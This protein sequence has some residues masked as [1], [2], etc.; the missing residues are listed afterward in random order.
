M[1]ANRLARLAAH[2]QP[3]RGDAHDYASRAAAAE[4]RPD[5]VVIVAAVRSPICRARR[6]GLAVVTPDA[7]LSQTLQGAMDRVPNL[8][9]AEL[10]DICI[11][12]VLQPGGGAGMARAAQLMAGI[13]PTVPLSTVNRQC[14]SGLQAV[15]HIVHAI[16]AGTIDCG[17]GGGVESMSKDSMKGAVPKLDWGGIKACAPAA[18]CLIPMG[19]TSE[20]VAKDFGISRREQDAFAAESQR[21]AA[22]S[23]RL[24]KFRAETVPIMTPKRGEM[25]GAPVVVTEDDG[26]RPG[27]DLRALGRL[28]PAFQKGGSTT[29]G[30][31]SQ[32]SDGAA[33]VILARRSYAEQRGWPVLGTFVA[34]AVV[35]VPPRIMGIGPVEAIPAV[36]AKAGL[37]AAD[38]DVFEINEAFASQA[39][40]CVKELGLDPRRVNPNGGAIALGHPLGCTGARQIA[41]LLEELRREG[42][43][44]GVV[45]M[46]VGT[47][48]G[49]A[50]VIRRC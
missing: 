17:V 6:G 35:G 18:D 47:G 15:A 20:N 10:G 29:A 44:I 8:N 19:V 50:S 32:V 25:G 24:G 11:G 16:R 4:D 28:K 33:A 21:R 23:R 27:T 49:A 36:L 14:S 22:E 37:A 39:L 40:Y 9:P 48:M 43:H 13:P 31:S 38:V 42:Q 46:C 3:S 41:T 7:L 1:E 34:H 5:D 45:S 12:N 26:I 30:N 2:L